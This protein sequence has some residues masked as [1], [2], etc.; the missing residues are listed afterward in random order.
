MMMTMTYLSLCLH[1]L[2]PTLISGAGAANFVSRSPDNEAKKPPR[3]GTLCTL[4][5]RE[6]LNKKNDDAS[7]STLSATP[8]IQR[9]R[10]ALPST[11]RSPVCCGESSKNT[12]DIT[13]GLVHV[14]IKA[15]DTKNHTMRMNPY[16]AHITRSSSSSSE[17]ESSRGESRF[18][19][20]LIVKIYPTDNENGEGEGDGGTAATTT[21]TTTPGDGAG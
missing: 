7:A 10:F 8:E 13:H 18:T 19:M 11:F 20:E 15:P 9:L 14:H 2:L 17:D 5:S 1:V 6:V 16:S 21:T 4:L 3:E 12:D